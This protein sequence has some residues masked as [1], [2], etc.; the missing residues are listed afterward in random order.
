MI[1]LEI[2]LPD[3][4]GA[5]NP[6]NLTTVLVNPAHVVLVG[7]CPVPTL[8]LGQMK[9]GTTWTLAHVGQ[10]VSNLTISEANAQL[11]LANAHTVH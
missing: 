4:Q 10:V 6:R 1:E 7:E 2:Y 5:P 3:G 9:S 11:A 8:I